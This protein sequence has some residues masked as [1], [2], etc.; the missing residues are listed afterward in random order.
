MPIT[1]KKWAFAVSALL[2]SAAGCSK[3]GDKPGSPEDVYRRFMLGNLSGDEKAIRTLVL[4]HP[5]AAILWSGGSYPAPVAEVLGKQYR[6]MKISRMTDEPER[7]VL[8]SPASPVPLE[9]R[10]VNGEW[11]ID[12]SPIIGFRKKSLAPP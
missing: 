5:E 11:R 2:L 3:A 12:A 10:R 7:V 4:D 9:V 6:E 1:F 8:Q